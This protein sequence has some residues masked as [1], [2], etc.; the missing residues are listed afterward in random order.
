MLKCKTKKK[1]Y[2]QIIHRQRDRKRNQ[3]FIAP[4]YNVYLFSSY[5]EH[6]QHITVR[7]KWLWK[8]RKIENHRGNT[9]KKTKKQFIYKSMY[10]STIF[11]YLLTA[12][13]LTSTGYHL[14][15][16]T[17]K[18]YWK[19]AKILMYSQIQ[20]MVVRMK[21][22]CF[23]VRRYAMKFQMLSVN[24]HL[25]NEKMGS[26]Q[27]QWNETNYSKRLYYLNGNKSQ[28]RFKVTFDMFS[29]VLYRIVEKVNLLAY[30]KSGIS[31]IHYAMF[32]GKFSQTMPS[33]F[34]KL[35]PIYQLHLF[36]VFS[37]FF[38]W[39]WIYFTL[40]DCTMALHYVPSWKSSDEMCGF[41]QKNLTTN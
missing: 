26:K 38:P 4:N 17:K 37:I 25:W 5:S 10:I 34:H 19:Y 20:L 2:T 35:F 29:F 30:L 22:E 16:R 27:S 31:Q 23:R 14:E 15:T 40:I 13:V 28:A 33:T 24:L 11:K 21:H 6:T 32:F 18:T 41:I 39:N 3:R 7:Q 1:S 12:Y 36:I 8:E 9:Q